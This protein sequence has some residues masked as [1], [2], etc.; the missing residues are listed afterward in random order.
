MASTETVLRLRPEFRV[1]SERPHLGL[2]LMVKNDLDQD[3]GFRYIQPFVKNSRRP[4]VLIGGTLY[5]KKSSYMCGE[6]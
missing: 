6:W 1:A 4:Y 3:H 5:I 2:Y